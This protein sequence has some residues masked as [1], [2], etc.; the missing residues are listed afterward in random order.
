M[1]NID[2]EELSNGF[3]IPSELPVQGAAGN[4]KDLHLKLFLA[5]IRVGMMQKGQIL[6]SPSKEIG[7]NLRG[8]RQQFYMLTRIYTVIPAG[9]WPESS[10]APPQLTPC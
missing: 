9:F 1:S 7:I 2:T 4:T 8:N 6:D 5:C 3:L 10:P